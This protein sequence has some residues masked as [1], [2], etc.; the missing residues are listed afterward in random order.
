MHPC[1]KPKKG[2]CTQTCN[3][4]KKWYACSCEAGYLLEDDKKTCKK[5][6]Q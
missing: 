2:G 5:G 4:R 1:D 3:K 6:E